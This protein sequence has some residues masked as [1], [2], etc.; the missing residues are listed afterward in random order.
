MLDFQPLTERDLDKLRPFLEKNPFRLC[1]LTVGGI[2]IWRDYYRTEYAISGGILYFK[3]YYPGFGTLFT[4]PQGGDRREEYRQIQEYCTRRNMPLAF[5]PI[6]KEELGALQDYFPCTTAITDRNSFDYLYR[7]EDLKYFRGKKLGGQRNHV[8]RFLRTYGNW[9]F[10]D[11]TSADA[12][13]IGA[14][15]DRYAAASQKEGGSFEEDLRKT[16]EVVRDLERYGMVGGALRVDGCMAGMSIGEVVGDTL[17][18]HIEKAD[19]AYEGCYQMLVSQFAQRFAGEGVAFINREDDTGDL[20]LRTSKL[21]YHP[22]ALLEKYAVVVEDD[23]KGEGSHE[24]MQADILNAGP[25]A[26]G[27]GGGA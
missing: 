14:F 18:T 11:I 16:R 5:Y 8:N 9:T 23:L 3:V 15:L 13:E 27:A 1:D 12:E 21:S 22:I 10:T 20:G 26:R 2:F 19:R 6:P 7:S 24:L 4:L 17:F 25:A